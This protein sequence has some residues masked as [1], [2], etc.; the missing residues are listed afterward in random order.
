MGFHA[1]LLVATVMLE[2]LIVVKWS[3]GEFPKPAPRYALSLFPL[4][5]VC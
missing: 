4:D 1:W 3:E 5:I 2:F